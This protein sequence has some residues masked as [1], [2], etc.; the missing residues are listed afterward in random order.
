MMY[1][2]PERPERGGG[3]SRFGK[4]L[5]CSLLGFVVLICGAGA[6]LLLSP[7]T[8]IIRDRLAAEVKQRTGRDLMIGG[9]PSLTFYPALASNWRTCRYRRRPPCRVRRC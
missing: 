1:R 5:L 3:G 7:P 6:L 2:K 4:I 9:K 8:G